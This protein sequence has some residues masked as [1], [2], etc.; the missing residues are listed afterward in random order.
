MSKVISSASHH[1]M[2][3]AFI[4]KR[5]IDKFGK[6]GE[7][8]VTDGVRHYG[9]QRGHRMALRTLADGNQLDVENYLIYGEWSAAPGE[10]DLRFPQYSPEVRMEN[11]KCPWYTEWEKRGLLKYGAYYCRDV[12]ASLARGYNGMELKLLA[13]RTRGDELCDFVFAGCSIPNERMAEFAAKRDKIDGKARMPWE[14]HI[15]HLYSA[16]REVIIKAFGNEGEKA[17]Q[18]AMDDYKNEYGQEAYDLVLQYADIDY[19]AM[20]KYEGIDKN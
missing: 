18:E 7:K 15:G 6:D 5:T 4:A 10:M 14:Y 3:F 20:P 11:H 19:N 1:A 17:V 2:L 8:A 16:M 9:E 12:D 13:N